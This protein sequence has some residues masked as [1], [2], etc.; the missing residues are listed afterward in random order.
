MKFREITNFSPVKCEMAV[1]PL[2]KR[3][4]NPPPLYHPLTLKLIFMFIDL[5]PLIL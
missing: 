3:D 2:V 5:P 1:V 4:P